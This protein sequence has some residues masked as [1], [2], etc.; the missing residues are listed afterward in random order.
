MGATENRPPPKKDHRRKAG[1]GVRMPLRPQTLHD[2][3]DGYLGAFY[4][5]QAEGEGLR[6]SVFFQADRRE[7]TFRRGWGC[8]P[9]RPLSTHP[10]CQN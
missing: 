1:P 9:P 3:L 10:L 6:G 8:L 2:L 4:V 5:R 7:R